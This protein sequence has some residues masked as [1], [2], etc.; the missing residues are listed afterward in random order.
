MWPL[1][2][3]SATCC[4]AMPE[5]ETLVRGFAAFRADILDFVDHHSSAVPSPPR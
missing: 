5:V 1:D 2:W 4:Q 3:R